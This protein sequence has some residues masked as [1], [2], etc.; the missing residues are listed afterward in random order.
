MK[1]LG[2]KSQVLSCIII[3][4]FLMLAWSTLS[5]RD[6]G[7]TLS[8]RLEEDQ[9]STAV[10]SVQMLLDTYDSGEYYL[11]GN[12]LYK[13]DFNITND[14]DILN[15]FS[16]NTELAVGIYLGDTEYALV[17]SDG[18]SISDTTI[19]S[20]IYET[21]LS[22]DYCFSSG[23]SINGNSFYGV[24]IKSDVSTDDQPV[25]LFAGVPTTVTE[26]M[27]VLR[28]RSTIIS[29]IV[30][31]VLC[32]TIAYF[33]VKGIVKRLNASITNLNEVASGHLDL[34][35]E[36][37]LL[38]R[39]DEVGVMAGS[40]QQVIDKFKNIANSLSDSSGTLT[41]FSDDIRSNFDNIN[42]SITN[43]STVIDEISNGATTQANETL[44][45]KLQMNDMGIAVDEATQ[46]IEL[47]KQS[48][49]T[50][51]SSN[52]A[53]NSNLSELIDIS[54][55]TEDS[56]RQV[57]EQTIE[58]NHSATEIQ[59]VVN[60]ISDIASQTNLLSLNASI[61]AA[62]A[63]EQGRGFAVVADEVRNLADQSRVS[64]EQIARIIDELLVKSNENVLAMDSVV[65]ET[66]Q[67]HEKL[68]ATQQV[69]QELNAEITN[70]VGAVENIRDIIERINR[71][72]DSV[73]S[74]LE[75]LAAISDENAASTQETSATV[76]ELSAIV[77]QCDGALTMLVSISE[78]LNYNVKQFSL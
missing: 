65:Q 34:S 37:N 27:Y 18:N 36:D 1:K 69:F 31:A 41:D 25:I 55:Q 9:L 71:S 33:L 62:R 40:I 39:Q 10:Y 30:M 54:Q 60:I 5:L 75:N 13:G 49:E 43:I 50:M 72:K 28:I 58:T 63:G 64:A 46:N 44:N 16:G 3:S 35:M 57:H 29:M 15:S 48:T 76:S 22:E 24:Y 32:A 17:D 42:E 23:I 53:V 8:G 21:V 52:R 20:D 14:S 56:I 26:S 6:L 38:E 4:L 66:H 12:E 74:N 77:A 67:Q 59:N 70:V 45:V 47:L 51:E 78:S 61:E 73:Y 68:E 2:L 7:V 11:D 19:S